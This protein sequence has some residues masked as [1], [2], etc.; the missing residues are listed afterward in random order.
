M[1]SLERYCPMVSCCFPFRWIKKRTR[2]PKLQNEAYLH[3]GICPLNGW[4]SH[5]LTVHARNPR[6]PCHP[7]GPWPVP[8]VPGSRK[9]VKAA[10]GSHWHSG[11]YTL[12]PYAKTKMVCF[13]K[14][15]KSRNGTSFG[16]CWDMFFHQN[17][18]SFLASV[19]GGGTEMKSHRLK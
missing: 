5:L 8:A 14:Y 17:L 10:G 2:H 9:V 3:S 7:L 6:L 1:R 11:S 15:P 13:E 19:Q 16:S 18:G 4:F 12:T